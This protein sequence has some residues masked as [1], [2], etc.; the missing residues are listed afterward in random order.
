MR[1]MAIWNTDSEDV[2]KIIKS[3]ADFRNAKYG[4]RKPDKMILPS[5]DISKVKIKELKQNIAYNGLIIG[6][7][8]TKPIYDGRRK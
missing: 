6:I 5:E 4:G 7:G 8:Q 1:I 2:I 3:R